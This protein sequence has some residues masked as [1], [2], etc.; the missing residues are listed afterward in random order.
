VIEVS[1]ITY[2]NDPLYLCTYEGF[3]PTEDHTIHAVTKSAAIFQQVREFSAPTI[4]DAYFPLGGCAA[5]HVVVSIVKQREGQAKNVILDILKHHLIK[6]CIVVDE[7]IDIRDSNQVEWAVA[8]R[9]QPDKD[10]IVVSDIIGPHLD[11]L[12]REGQPSS[13]YGI[14]ATKPLNKPFPVTA[15][16]DQ[17]AMDKMTKKWNS[18]LEL[19]TRR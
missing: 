14:D 19:K 11:P 4:R 9:V 6:S 10:I 12:A 16:P 17:G 2:R 8:T 5:F 13:K 7:D 15:M 18:M 1:A 3:P